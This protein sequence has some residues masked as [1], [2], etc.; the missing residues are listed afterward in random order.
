M[1]HPDPDYIPPEKSKNPEDK[2]YSNPGNLSWEELLSKYEL[3]GIEFRDGFPVFD[4]ISR[5][6]VEIDDFE[7]GGNDAK[8]RNFARAD[9]QMAK[10]RGCSPEEVKQ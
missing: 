1:W 6:T 8:N 7:T 5:G 9:I 4:E 10:E 2:P 3:T